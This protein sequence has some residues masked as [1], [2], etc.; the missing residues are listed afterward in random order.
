M[1]HQEVKDLDLN[2]FLDKGR[3][4]ITQGKGRER[5]LLQW[6]WCAQ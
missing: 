2:T 1:C 6:V 3:G 4:Q 5:T